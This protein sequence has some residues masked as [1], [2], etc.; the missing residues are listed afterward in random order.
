MN[1]DFK[2]DKDKLYVKIE[3]E[4]DLSVATSFRATLEEKIDVNQARHLILDFSQVSF[5]DSSG[6][7]VILGRYKRL[8]EI[9]GTVQIIGVNEQIEKILELSGL[10]RIMDI[11]KQA[12]KVFRGTSY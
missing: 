1:L 2:S 4:L 11:R 10:S 5:I 9:G 6:L 8:K 12:D 7:G 3:G